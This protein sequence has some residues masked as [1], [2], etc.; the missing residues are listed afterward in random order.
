MDS[1]FATTVRI[2]RDSRYLQRA[3]L[4]D[5]PQPQSFFKYHF[6]DELRLFWTV[7]RA[8]MSERVLLLFSSRGRFKPELL[9]AIVV[10]FWP[11]RYQPII[12]LYGEM[13]QPDTGI[14]LQIERVL[15]RLA[16][17]AISRYI[18]ASQ[19]EIELFSKLWQVEPAKIR[20]CPEYTRPPSIDVASTFTMDGHIF[21]GGN[22]FRDFVPLIDVARELP[23]HQFV[24]CTSRLDGYEN[25]P[26]NVRAGLVPPS[27]YSR[28]IGAAKLVI[29]PIARDVKRI[30]GVLT[31]LEAMWLKKVV[32]VPSVA[33]A[34]EYIDHKRTGLLVDGTAQSYIDTIAWALA[35]ENR[36]KAEMICQDAHECA[37]ACF[38]RDKHIDR[39]FAIMDELIEPASQR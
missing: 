2:N 4:L 28:L 14:L 12:A 22:S 21:A 30:V 35:P 36:S 31:Y 1:T 7:V 10:G 26:P 24:F 27:E 39:L 38:S 33:G 6:A 37:A 34:D 11:Q 32:I 17:R 20:V 9:A 3:K 23:Q 8:A 5:I 19:A 18:V 15:L 16:D 25:L 29:V 13:Y